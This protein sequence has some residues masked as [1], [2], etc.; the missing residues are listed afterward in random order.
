MRPAADFRTTNRLNRLNRFLQILLAVAFVGGLN[1]LALRYHARFDLTAHH[2]YSL[3]PETRA[4]VEQLE[5]P[6]TIYVTLRDP[7]D[8]PE[9]ELLI[10]YVRNL[11]EEY[12]ATATR[13]N[14]SFLNV[15]YIDIFRER[16]RAE[17]LARE[18]GLQEP[19]IVLVTSRD[20]QRVLL[21]SD[22]LEFA[23]REPVAFRGEEAVTSA[24][25]EVVQPEAPRVYSLVGHGEMRLDDV[26]PLRGLSLLAEQLR[27]RNIGTEPLDLTK[28]E[29]V[30]EDARAI[31]V[32]SPQGRLFS[33]EVEKLRNFLTQRG[34]RLLVYL[35]PW[36]DHGMEE[37]LFEWGI[38]ADDM[39]VIDLAEDV[40]LPGG[41]SL[42]GQYTENHPVTNFLLANQIRV[43]TGLSRPIRPDL[44]RALDDRLR[45]TPLMGSS[46]TSWAES[47]YRQSSDSGLTYDPAVDL[48]GPV[49]MAVA[50]ERRISSQLGINLTG[51]RVLVFGNSD[52]VANNR[53]AQPGNQ[54]LALNAIAWLL[55]RR[56][57]LTISPRPIE[58][59]Q[60]P[61]TETQLGRISLTL[62]AFPVTAALLGLIVA[63][64]RKR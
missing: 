30:P 18:F 1:S 48:P 11:L 53:L 51:G 40:R 63:F 54:I 36:R 31:I 19:Q 2:R 57:M 64:L 5:E 4:Y 39:V 26:D 9:E 28:Q 47:A 32:A 29:S 58:R 46:G 25:L 10:R 7:G 27:L 17:T 41:D 43:V 62:A 24:I 20:R 34:G 60:I 49:S 22:L 56:Q 44:G 15:E 61:L 55:D 42:V 8:T 14:R 37:L 52:I 3:S 59:Y 16:Q 6:V 13:G 35:D 50:S 21:P 45:V 23:D 12:Q 38:R 33:Q